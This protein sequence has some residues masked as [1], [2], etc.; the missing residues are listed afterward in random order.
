MGNG[1]VFTPINAG[2]E[3]DRSE[4]AGGGLFGAGEGTSHGR[5]AVLVV[6]GRLSIMLT[7]KPSFTH[8]PAAFASQCIDVASQDFL[9]VKRG[10]GLNRIH[11]AWQIHK[12]TGR[13]AIVGILPG[14]S[15]ASGFLQPRQT[16]A[17]DSSTSL[18][19]SKVRS[20]S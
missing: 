7:S 19:N 14:T 10:S 16:S 8:D 13:L 3:C 4:R 11:C 20:P 17:A 15:A 12:H 5:T 1:S 2:G 18:C 9:V 6:D